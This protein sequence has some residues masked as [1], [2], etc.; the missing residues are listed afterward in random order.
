MPESLNALVLARAEVSMEL[1]RFFPPSGSRALSA[2]S[3]LYF[4]SMTDLS[5]QRDR[6]LPH[7]LIVDGQVD[8]LSENLNQLLDFQ[9]ASKSPILLIG[10][11]PAG[12]QL[13][14]NL[15]GICNLIYPL[16]LSATVLER[17]NQEV[18]EAF[19]KL[20]IEWKRGAFGSTDID[21]V[22]AALSEKAG[23]AWKQQTI[24]SYTPKGGV[25]KT[26][27]AI[28]P[29]VILA[30]LGGLK[31][32]I[33]DANMN[34]GH[35]APMLGLVSKDRTIYDLAYQYSI[36]VRNGEA[37]RA[38]P[39][40]LQRFLIPVPGAPNLVV[41]AGV[42]SQAQAGQEELQGE[43]GQKFINALLDTLRSTYDFVF[44]DCGSSL[45]DMVHYQCLVRSD[46][47]LM[48]C[49]SSL[50]S[51]GDIAKQV[52]DVFPKH[53]SSIP[54][55]RIKCVVNMLIEN[56]GFPV[57]RIHE[58]TKIPVV[59]VVP[60]CL[61]IIRTS[62]E[63]A[64]FTARFLQSYKND[65]NVEEALSGFVNIAASFY[66]PIGAAWAA[67]QKK[68]GGAPSAEGGML[69]KLFGG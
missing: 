8:G 16:P 38:F 68:S 1:M 7:I 48:V 36:L 19:Q 67:R 52:E 33:V 5:V 56:P 69:K 57:E 64:S 28:E 66:K 3:N 34:G 63:H 13:L 53:L 24:T 54:P 51:M 58:F 4:F 14:E 2:V 35:V 43:L 42:S 25:G 27:V 21:L 60:F 15:H 30:A 22:R 32:A 23:D 20:S 18:P 47:I 55:E 41:L 62:N 37:G 49:S 46:T 40:L 12:S 44:I 45:N 39:S 59:G 17:M 29:A 11:A 50:Q 6:S 10:L 31:I 61:E 9:R 26:T 65:K